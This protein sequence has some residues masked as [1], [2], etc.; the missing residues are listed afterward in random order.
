MNTQNYPVVVRDRKMETTDVLCLELA[1]LGGG[2]LPDFAPG[3]YVDVRLPE[4]LVRSYS[5]VRHA[6]DRSCYLIAV[7]R[8]AQ[9]RGGSAALHDTVEVGTQLAISDPKGDFT[10]VE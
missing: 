1:S 4:G 3:A 7:K 8:E 9:G 2:V 10:L 5:L 6:A